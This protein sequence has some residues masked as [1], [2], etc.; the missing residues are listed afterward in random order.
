MLI[1]VPGCVDGCILLFT[2]WWS[3]KKGN[4]YKKAVNKFPSEWVTFCIQ[5]MIPICNGSYV[6]LPRYQTRP[7]A[8]ADFYYRKK[9]LSFKKLFA[10]YWIFKSKDVK[11]Y[12]PV[13]VSENLCTLTLSLFV[14][15]LLSLRQSK[16]CLKIKNICVRIPS[17]FF[18][19]SFI[20]WRLL[21]HIQG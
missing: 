3:G 16:W 4:R 15:F 20:I 8:W 7:E 2:C 14:E 6:S 21:L 5:D 1:E 19:N 18:F 11:A 13:S 17:A 9:K 10:W 12:T